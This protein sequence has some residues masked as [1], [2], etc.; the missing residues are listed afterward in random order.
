M[1]PVHRARRRPN[2]IHVPQMSRD[3]FLRFARLLLIKLLLRQPTTNIGERMLV[4]RVCFAKRRDQN[5]KQLCHLSAMFR[6]RREERDDL[7]RDV[8]ALKCGLRPIEVFEIQ[9]FCAELLFVIRLP[10]EQQVNQSQ[11]E[12]VQTVFLPMQSSQRCSNAF[13]QPTGQTRSLCSLCRRILHGESLGLSV[14]LCG[15]SSWR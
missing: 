5:F 14:W 4:A 3:R 7:R 6:Q 1:L 13:C 9:E 15:S 2:L 8:A 10:R 11:R 12:L